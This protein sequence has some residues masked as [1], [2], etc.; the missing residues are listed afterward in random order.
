MDGPRTRE[1]DARDSAWVLAIA[2]VP[3]AAAMGLAMAGKAAVGGLLVQASFLLIPL[4]Y[5][6]RAGLGTL[7]GNG[8][9]PLPP[10]RIAFVLLA[11]LGSLWLLNGLTHLQ[12]LA[13]RALGWQEKAQAQ[14]EVIRQG[15]ETVQK[16][17]VA[18]TLVA[19]VVLPPLCE[20][21]FFRGVLFRGLLRRFR[22]VVAIGSTTVL[23]A[24][25][26][27]MDV[28]K[29][30]MLFVGGYFGTLVYLT[31]SLWA[32]ILAH[33]VNNLAVITL[34]WIYEGRLPAIVGPWWMYLLSAIVFAL[35]M[36]LLVLDRKA[37]A[38]DSTTLER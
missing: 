22:P 12:D 4:L 28:Q 25:F 30:L 32:G 8:F 23:F 6:R 31:G 38:A 9:A 13:V 5:A 24:W 15:I 11:S 3:I 17:G 29:F 2:L 16:R 21:L 26:H 35:G 33:A 1:P 34:M 20:E 10:R 19:F 36:A 14:S 37:S 7:A 18:P 27:G